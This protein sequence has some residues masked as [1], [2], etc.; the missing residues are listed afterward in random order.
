M[1]LVSTAQCAHYVFENSSSLARDSSHAH[2]RSSPQARRCSE[3]M[4]ERA[5]CWTAANVFVGS[6]RLYRDPTIK[7]LM[8]F[9]IELCHQKN[10]LQNDNINNNDDKHSQG[11][12]DIL[13]FCF[14]EDSLTQ[15]FL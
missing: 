12:E 2:S 14:F 5:N 10:G 11:A 7:Q 3:Q 9:I 4:S 15:K 13:N 8:S 1:W 6:V